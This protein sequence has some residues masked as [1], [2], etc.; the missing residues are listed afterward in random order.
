MMS[1]L[2]ANSMYWY[3]S[4][5]FMFIVLYKV[6]ISGRKK[7][8]YS[9]YIGF[10]TGFLWSFNL[11]GLISCQA[12]HYPIWTSYQMPS[13]LF[14]KQV[15]QTRWNQQISNIV[16]EINHIQIRPRIILNRKKKI[17]LARWHS[18]VKWIKPCLWNGKGSWHTATVNGWQRQ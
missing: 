18:D 7:Y 10:K 16:E 3:N 15:Q 11:M 1:D 17:V 12:S 8:L 4:L 14:Y 2:K 9:L 6:I 13:K 5:M